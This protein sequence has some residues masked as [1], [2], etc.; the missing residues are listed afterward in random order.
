MASYPDHPHEKTAWPGAGNDNF[1]TPVFF[2]RQVLDAYLNEPRYYAVSDTYV[3]AGNMW[4]IEIAITERGNVQ[5]WLGDLGR[6]SERAQRH[7]QQYAIPDDDVVPEWRA[8]QD[9]LAEF[10]D[11]PKDEGIDRVKTGIEKCN[12]AAATYCGES[13]FT[14]V[15]GM[16][17]QR[18]ETLH[19]PLN[20]SQP[21][22]QQ[23]VTSLAI[24]IVDHLNA[25][26]LNK[27]DAPKG[28]GQLKRLADWL[29]FEL[30]LSDTEAKEI[31]R[32]C[33]A[34]YSIRSEAGGAHRASGRASEVLDRAGIDLDDLPAGF[35]SLAHLVAD[36]LNE[37]HARLSGLANSHGS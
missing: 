2:K 32:G 24:L 20:D 7:W 33:Y 35:E 19:T 30:S 14:R 27:V 1:L 22:F 5:V 34:V 36:S 9:L 29:A 25:A 23:Q 37:L 4:G 17:E 31:L 26:F 13:L 18:I 11:P 15:E 10:V 6:I 21:E 3:S 28:E 12:E 16:N 8:R